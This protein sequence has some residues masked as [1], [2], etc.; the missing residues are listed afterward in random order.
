MKLDIA[1][2]EWAV[3]CDLLTNGGLTLILRK[4]GIHESGGPGVFA[5]AHDRFLMYPSWLHQKPELVKPE[6]RDQVEMLD[7]PDTITFTGYGEV[8]KIWEVPDRESF[9]RLDDLHCWA[10]EQINIRFNYKP[11]NPLYLV[12]IRGYQLANT[13]TIDNLMEYS[14]C[15]SWVPLK[16]DA[17]VEINDATPAVSDDRIAE[18]IHRVDETFS[19]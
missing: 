17:A 6:F 7:E 8:A 10:D 13:K 9:D 5:M 2:K 14:G 19:G 16:E 18:I 11:Q 15:R 1:L 3:V 4:G 12:A